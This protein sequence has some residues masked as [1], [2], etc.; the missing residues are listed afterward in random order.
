MK[1]YKNKNTSLESEETLKMIERRKKEKS[2]FEGKLSIGSK[3]A[4]V[5]VVIVIVVLLIIK[6]YK[7]KSKFTI[8]FDTDG[9]N[10]VTEQ[11]IK[12][13]EKAYKPEEPI[14]DGYKFLGWYLDG[15]EYD[16][17]TKVTKNLNIKAKW[18][19]LNNADVS[20]VYLDQKELVLIPNDSVELIATVEPLDAKNKNIKWTSTNE[21]VATVDSNG[22]VKSH[23]NG[24]TNIVV[25]TEEG[26]FSD[27]CIVVVSND[28]IK[29]TGLK[30]EEKNIKIK[31]DE[32]K[33]LDVVV[34][35]LNATN[36][37]LLWES[38]NTKIVTVNTKGIITGINEGEAIITI[39]TKEG[40]FTEKIKVTVEKQ[41]SK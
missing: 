13:N 34:E 16:F 7:T 20:G 37:G 10:L 2:G 35:P 30:V 28:T 12:I 36:D 26:D 14:K 41:K 4:I 25:T 17:D 3:L 23:N 32:S 6:I 31:I 40:D 21:N 38:D 29:V 1:K 22:K 27:K 9:G 11:Y 33:K 8:K 19:S 18:E 39:K 24:V 5:L 15:K